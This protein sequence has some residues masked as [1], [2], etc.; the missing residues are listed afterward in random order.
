MRTLDTF[1]FELDA[2]A[3]MA[4]VHVEPGT[5]DADAFA[6]LVERA[7]AVARPKVAFREAFVEA[8]GEETVRLGG[9][10]FTSRMLRA[11]LDQ[12]E[13][14]FAYVATCGREVHEVPMEE[15][16]LLA[17]FWWDAIKQSLLGCALRALNEELKR[18]YRLGRTSAMSPGSG[19]VDVWPIEQQ[20]EL[21]RLVGDVTG[22]IG[23]A[24]TPSYLMVPNKSVS[25]LRFPAEADFYACQVCRREVCQGRRAPFDEALWRSIQHD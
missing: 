4:L 1:T 14:A 24:L 9:V 15:G 5:E 7:R 2:D 21:F 11:N 19:D 13:R 6:A 16:D 18:R 10:T 3:L 8:R 12:V 23:V 22:A 17:A 20:R 25:G